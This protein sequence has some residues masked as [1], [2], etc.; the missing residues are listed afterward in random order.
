VDSGALSSRE[1]ANS[2]SLAVNSSV[3]RRSAC[4]ASL[5]FYVSGL[6]SA[7]LGFHLGWEFGPGVD[8]GAGKYSD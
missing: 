1:A 8:V 3:S 5:F 4:R 2:E 7:R 6:T